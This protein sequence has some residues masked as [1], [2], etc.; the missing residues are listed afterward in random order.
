MEDSSIEHKTCGTTGMLLLA[1]A[2]H[3]PDLALITRAACHPETFACLA[4]LSIVVSSC[5]TN[6]FYP[7]RDILFP[8]SLQIIIQFFF[9]PV[10]CCSLSAL[11]RTPP[12]LL[13]AHLNL[14]N[15]RVRR[16]AS[17]FLQVAVSKALNPTV[18]VS[19]YC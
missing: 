16:K 5:P 1:D 12:H 2:F 17:G 7:P 10:G 6:F 18:L 15:D 4:A 8:W 9:L 11:F 14:H 19:A 3:S 13:F